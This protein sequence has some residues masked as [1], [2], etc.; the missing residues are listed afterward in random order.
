MA[1][2]ESEAKGGF[3]PTPPNE[4]ELILK[5]IKAKEG[6]TVTLLDPCAGEGLALRQIQDH[7]TNTGTNSITYGIELEKSR[8]KKAKKVLDNVLACGYEDVRMSHRAFSFMYLNPPFGVFQGERLEKMFFRDLT[9]PNTYLTEGSLVVL[10]MPQHVLYSMAN[11][12]AQRLEKVRVYRFT[13]KN[14]PV[15]KQIILYGYR[16]KGRLGKDETLKRK[17]ETLAYVSPEYIP[18]LETEDWDE[19]QYNIP[20]S[21]REVSLFDTNFVEAE[22]IIRS[23]KEVNVMEKVNFKISNPKL[24][25]IKS[26]NP[27]MPLKT[28]HMATAIAS[29]AVPEQM[30]DHL[31]VGVTKTKV[32]EETDFDLETESEKETV[33]YQSKSLI[34]VFSEQGIFDLD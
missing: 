16:R 30:G 25:S 18:T 32:T 4:M 9:K 15:Y 22:D 17:L 29:G 10:N 13:D 31:L 11:L 27:A 24:E 12:I 34:R 6:A 5:R 19:V 2:L 21:E 7:L 26:K 28:T 23:M 1:R 3:Y 33:I 20:E 14:F 8:A